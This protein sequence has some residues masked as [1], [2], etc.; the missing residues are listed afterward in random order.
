MKLGARLK[1]VRRGAMHSLNAWNGLVLFMT[2]FFAFMGAE[3]VDD[4]ADYA[5]S[6]TIL[7]FALYWSMFD[8]VG[9]VLELEKSLAEPRASLQAIR[10]RATVLPILA[11]LALMLLT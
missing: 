2:I 3:H 5:V 8:L 1:V 11:M 10:E 9:H 4:T 6:V 7:V